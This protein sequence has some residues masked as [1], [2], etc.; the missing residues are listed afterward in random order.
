MKIV[1]IGAGA[2]F[3]GDRIDP[4]IDLAREGN[5]D[6]LVFECLAER[7]IALAQ[8][9]KRQGRGDGFDP[10]L[11]RRMEAV[12]PLCARNGTRIITNMGAANPEAAVRETTSIARA[13]GLS[14]MRIA[15]V[16]G[17]DVLHLLAGHSSPQPGEHLV[18]AN[19][20]LGIEPIL[21]CLLNGANVI[22]TGRVA[23]PSLFLAPMV[24]E[25]SWRLDDWDR[26]GQ[27]TAVGHLLEC[28]G[29]LTGG[30]FADPGYK[31]VAGLDRL[32]FPLAE[33][34]ETGEALL[35]KLSGSGGGLTIRNCKE[36]ILYEVQDP[37]RYL[38]PDVSA[39]F[40]KIRFA[41]L[42]ADKIHVAG[43]VGAERPLNLKVSTGFHA[44]FIADGQ[45]SYAGPG[46]LLRAQLA[47]Q[48]LENRLH[49]IPAADL[50]LDFIGI[51]SIHGATLSESS[52]E[53]YE[54]RLRAAGRFFDE[55][56]AELLIH[57]VESLYVNGPAGGGGVVTGLRENIAMDSTFLSRTSIVPTIGLEVA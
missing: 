31:D 25:F 57:E 29:Q 11:R 20:Y 54:V 48:I 51:D 21:D 5:L 13:L 15:W 35:T 42:S 8:L 36:Q 38:T 12:L 19:A 17:D 10:M 41:E 26:L 55:H 50:R 56:H 6:Y 30:Y 40:T 28:A 53:P 34:D 2:G 7:T 46:A 44:G 22:I 39:D 3:A 24:H 18:S 4:A 16:K 23:D 14:G 47:R 37:S 33:V 43:A 49:W 32:G 52:C 9:S 27:G 1:R 45:I